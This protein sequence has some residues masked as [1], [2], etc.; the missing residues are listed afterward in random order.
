MPRP[1]TLKVNV[2]HEQRLA[3]R[4]RDLLCRR[5]APR[6]ARASPRDVLRERLA[7]LGT[8]RVDLIGVASV[9]GDDAGA[10]ARGAA[11]PA[12]R[13]TCACASR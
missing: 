7:A 11:A 2:F 5:R 6:R 4:G 9:F 10:L 3:R 12:R 1:A 8:L 13:A